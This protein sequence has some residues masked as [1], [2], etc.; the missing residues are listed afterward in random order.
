MEY[1]FATC[2][3]HS[4]LML[5]NTAGSNKQGVAASVIRRRKRRRRRRR[6]QEEVVAASVFE[7]AS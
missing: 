6:R 5:H 2:M 3:C 4:G 7:V 1:G